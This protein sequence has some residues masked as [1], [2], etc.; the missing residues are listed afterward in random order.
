MA[1]G[2]VSVLYFLGVGSFVGFFVSFIFLFAMT[3][4][5]N[6]STYRMIP[7]IFRTERERMSR[8]TS[9]SGLAEAREFGLKEGSF[10]LGFVGA[11]GAYGGFIIPQAYRYSI[12]AT[13]G[14]Q[15]ALAAFVAF[16]V[17]CIAVTWFFYARRK[18]EI[19]C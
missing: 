17:T 4:V 19:A 6:G 13:G 7:V 9:E 10:V 15:I 16:Y 11:I 2:V 14:P 18:A 8:D 12:E 5:G 3:G 1:L